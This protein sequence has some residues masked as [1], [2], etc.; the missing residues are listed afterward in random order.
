MPAVLAVM[1]VLAL[2]LWWLRKKGARGW[3]RART[4]RA[5]RRL[6]SMERLAL[7]PHHTL[8]L[9]RLDDHA[10][11]VAQS[12]AGLTLLEGIAVPQVLRAA[13]ATA[14]ERG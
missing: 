4:R 14:S 9:V 12:P 11:L 10:I 1:A 2:A 5:A 13:A 3:L 8:Y 6:E 7:A